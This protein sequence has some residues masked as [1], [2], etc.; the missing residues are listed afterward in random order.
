MTG[1]PIGRPGRTRRWTS[2]RAWPWTARRR[3]D[4][5]PSLPLLREGLPV[6]R[7]ETVSV[8]FPELVGWENERA[9]FSRTTATAYGAGPP[10]GF[11]LTARGGGCS[12]RE[13][14]SFAQA[15]GC[16]F[17]RWYTK[18]QIRNGQ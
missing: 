15:N 5:V 18:E 8:H 1:S 3:S 14:W 16:P 2:S 4:L 10:S 9:P 11:S 17:P 12:I 7:G 6:S 13:G